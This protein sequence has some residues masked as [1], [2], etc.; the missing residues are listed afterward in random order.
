MPWNM[1]T[2]DLTIDLERGPVYRRAVKE[3][4]DICNNCDFL[5]ACRTKNSDNRDHGVIAAQTLDE[6]VPRPQPTIRPSCGTRTGTKAHYKNREIACRACLDAAAEAARARPV[7]PIAKCGTDSGYHRHVRITK[8]DA[9]EPCLQAHA[10]AVRLRAQ[11]KNTA[12]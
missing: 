10:T 1:E 5:D 11:A 4:K 8:T 12:A 2:F 6:R 9:C 7:R 3:A